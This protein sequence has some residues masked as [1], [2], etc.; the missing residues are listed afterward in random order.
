M[1]SKTTINRILN[2]SY[3]YDPSKTVNK[4]IETI[5]YY[6]VYYYDQTSNI[7]RVLVKLTKDTLEDYTKTDYYDSWSIFSP[8]VCT[9]ILY[10]NRRVT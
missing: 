7:D 10:E 5:D 8:T 1:L 6:K 9:V 2:A 4:I 3:K